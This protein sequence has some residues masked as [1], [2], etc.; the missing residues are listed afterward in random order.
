MDA[1]LGDATVAVLGQSLG[2]C[3][4]RLQLNVDNTVIAPSFWAALPVHLPHLQ[5]LSLDWWY[6]ICDRDAAA[7]AALANFMRTYSGPPLCLEMDGSLCAAMGIAQAVPY[8]YGNS[9]V[10]LPLT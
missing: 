4:A 10:Q 2:S 3:L 5:H 8:R 1:A 6:P 9:L 7:D